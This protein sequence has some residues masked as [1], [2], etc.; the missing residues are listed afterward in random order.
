MTV[1]LYYQSNYTAGPGPPVIAPSLSLGKT[2]H[3][4]QFALLEVNAIGLPDFNFIFLNIWQY[5]IT[6]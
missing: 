4:E 5:D 3:F 2:A 6:G 1:D